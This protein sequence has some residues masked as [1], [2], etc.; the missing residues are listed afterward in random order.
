MH[1]Y[2]NAG[3]TNKGEVLGAGIG[4]GSNS[5]FFSLSK[6]KKDSKMGISLEIIDQ[7]NDFLY[8]AFENNDDFRRYW[9]DY[10]LHLNFN[11]KLKNTWVSVNLVYNR[12][13]NYQWE[14]EENASSY[15][16]PGRDVDNFHANIKM[17]YQLPIK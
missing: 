8:Y 16:Q 14:L 4:P 17:I 15:Y 9:K 13:L 5:H 12:S 11:K 3:F 10:N 1:A 7:D 6:I 2:V